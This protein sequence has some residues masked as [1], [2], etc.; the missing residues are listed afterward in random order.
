MSDRQLTVSL[1]ADRHAVLIV[2]PTLTP[3]SLLRLEQGLAAALGKLRQEVSSQGTDPGEIEY[4][5]WMQHLRPS[6]P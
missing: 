4:L 5:S 6:R 2:P 3:E 1:A